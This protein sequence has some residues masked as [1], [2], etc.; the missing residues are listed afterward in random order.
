[1]SKL[2]VYR[3]SDHLWGTIHVNW[4]YK[5]VLIP[6]NGIYLVKQRMIIKQKVGCIITMIKLT[7]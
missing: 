6:T 1:M 4:L 2:R 5:T 7:T 3:C